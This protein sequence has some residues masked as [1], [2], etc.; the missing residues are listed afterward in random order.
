LGR[1]A[2]TQKK[3]L[4]RWFRDE[5]NQ[6]GSLYMSMTATSAVVFSLFSTSLA[7]RKARFRTEHESLKSSFD[8]INLM[9]NTDGLTGVYNHRYLHEKLS[10]EVEKV[11]RYKTPL[12]C[13]MADLDDF[14]KVNDHHGHAFGDL[15]LVTVARIIRENIRQVDILGRYGGEE[16]LVVMPNTPEDVAYVIAERIR[17][18]VESYVYPLNTANVRVTMSLGIASA[19]NEHSDKVGLLKAADEALY[20][21]KQQG[22]NRVS[23]WKKEGNY[24]RV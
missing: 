7:K 19:S 13:L 20:Q 6:H 3:F 15:V 16:F 11:A 8:V 17:R 24:S 1:L 9:A 5:W 22:K 2:T 12:T 10:L 14:K 21:A 4:R 18:S 23:V